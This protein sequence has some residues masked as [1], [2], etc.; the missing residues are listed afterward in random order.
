MVKRSRLR[1]STA[2]KGRLILIVALAGSFL[3]LGLQHFMLQKNR[4]Q[5]S[6]FGDVGIQGEESSSLL[7]KRGVIFDR[8]FKKLAMTL[9][10]VSVYAD[11]RDVNVNDVITKLGPVLDLEQA[12]LKK[13]LASDQYKVWLVKNISQQKEEII[14][15]LGLPGIHLYKKRARYYPHKESAAHVVGFVGD[16]L[17]LAGVEYAYNSLLNRYGSALLA[18]GAESIVPSIS[19]G[20]TEQYI[21]LTIDLKI[22]RI[23]ENYVAELARNKGDVRIG[24]MLM[25]TKSAE[26]IAQAVYPTFDPNFF[27]EYGKEELQ[28]IFTEQVRVPQKIRKLL[29]DASVL[30]S[31]YEKDET[32]V[33]W[34]IASPQRDIGSQLRLWEHLGFNDPLREDFAQEKDGYNAN[35]ETPKPLSA[36]GYDAVVE[37]TT[38]MHIATAINSLS[39]GG[40][41]AVP[42]LVDRIAGKDGKVLR[43]PA[44]KEKQAT[45]EQV[46]R[47][48]RTM[49]Q[50]QMSPGPLSAG[51]FE[52]ESVHYTQTPQG[53]KYIKNNLFFSLIPVTEPEL[54][55]FVFTQLSPFPPSSSPANVETESTFSLT[56]S[57]NKITT[58]VVAMQKV[59]AN[60]SDMMSAEEKREMNFEMQGQLVENVEPG[61]FVEVDY[62]G[63][64]PD[65]K[66][67]SLRKSLRMLKDLKLEIQIS[68]TGVVVNQ[69]PVAGGQVRQNS[70]CRLMLKPH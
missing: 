65:L 41:Q 55:L 69:N 64:M 7:D 52:T 12:E 22:Q 50:A 42:H 25:D 32:V 44:T 68:G 39:R 48:I 16:G 67:M 62:I 29:W 38:P 30:Q 56:R 11:V 53:R 15:E 18:A 61:R 21:V 6:F 58:S 3:F 54:M 49:M 45:A 17:G 28:N 10:R 2:S 57:A 23:L 37:V 40:T 43:L 36:D 14:T 9:D 19:A 51:T 8:N 35:V 46:A 59:M 20:D 4:V 31:N 47:E 33:P 13:L 1:N 26:I 24:A 66:G 27:H 60:L 34:S 5:E 70:L 63:T